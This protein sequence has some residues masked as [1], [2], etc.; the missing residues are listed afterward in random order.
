MPTGAGSFGGYQAGTPPAGGWH[1]ETGSG[2]E[3]KEMAR[4]SA[5][6]LQ[7]RARDVADQAKARGSQ[8]LTSQKEQVAGQ[9]EGF[10]GAL[11]RTAESLRSEG[12]GNDTVARYAEAAS[13][14]I[15]DVGRALRERDLRQIVSDVERFA[16]REPLLFFGGAL[17]L[18]FAAT[19]FFKSSPDHAHGSRAP[20]SEAQG[21]AAGEALAEVPSQT[22]GA[23]ASLAQEEGSI[24]APEAV[25]YG[26]VLD[27]P[28]EGYTKGGG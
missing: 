8:A 23:A 18:G 15:R 4:R 2:G 11:A 13:E 5:G 25:G 19:R 12:D 20:V 28:A 27:D 10:A 22:S 9:F 14:R 1:E 7:E 21:E 26:R 3:V 16:R 17:A 24:V 6:E